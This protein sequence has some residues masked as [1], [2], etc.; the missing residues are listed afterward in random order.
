MAITP[1]AKSRGTNRA[2]MAELIAAHRHSFFGGKLPAYDGRKSIYTAGALPFESKDFVVKL[3][4]KDK[5]KKGKKRY[6]LELY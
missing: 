3:G 2:V 4:D 5:E 1:E 6:I